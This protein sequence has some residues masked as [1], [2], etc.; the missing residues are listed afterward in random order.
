MGL[1]G[2]EELR[3]FVD[4]GGVLITL[5]DS[6]AM[7]ADYDL[8][9]DVETGKPAGDFYAPGPIVNAKVTKTGNPIFYG[10][11]DDT[12]PVRWATS[13]LFA[14]PSYDRADVL[15]EF[16][17]GKKNVLSGLMNGADSIKHRPAIIDLPVGQGRILMFATNPI[18]R[19]QNFG[20]YRMLYNALFSYKQLRLGTDAPEKA[21]DKD[22]DKADGDTTE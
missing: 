12:I 21:P 14:L 9:P 17:G 16:P 19:W 8:A 22:E 5:G 3:K 4:E 2:L 20:E 6:S 7:P 1:E 13:T 18:Y 15:M 10:Y 11:D